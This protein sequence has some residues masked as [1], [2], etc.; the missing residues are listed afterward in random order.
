MAGN[1]ANL[2]KAT[3]AR[4]AAA[5]ARAEAALTA[6]IKTGEPVTFRGLAARG[7]VSLDFL[8]RNTAIRTRIEHHRFRAA[9]PA[10]ARS[11]RPPRPEPFR[12]RGA[13]A[14][15]PARRSQ[16]P[17]PRGNHRPASGPRTGTRREPP[18]AEAARRRTRPRT[19]AMT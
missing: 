1:L 10:T 3:A 19:R 12:Q 8:Y 4:T 5:T 9:A 17:P 14:D 6:M 2:Q 13:H 7:G 15:R 16:T 11:R 18:P